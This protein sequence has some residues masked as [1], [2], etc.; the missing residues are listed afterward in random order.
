MEV[1]S[2]AADAV[3]R[4]CFTACPQDPVT[5]LLDVR[6]AKVFKRKHIY[7]ARALTRTFMLRQ[8]SRPHPR[9]QRTHFADAGVLHQSDCQR[10][11]AAGEA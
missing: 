3:F 7:Q 5:L 11:D 2:I 1:K 6:S 9:V 4:A 10:G 8:S